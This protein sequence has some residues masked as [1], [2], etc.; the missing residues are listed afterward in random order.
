MTTAREYLAPL[1]AAYRTALAGL[2][3]AQQ[4]A[5][6]CSIGIEVTDSHERWQLTANGAD[7]TVTDEI[8]EP[9]DF[10]VYASKA[11]IDQ[12]VNDNGISFL[13][14][15]ITTGRIVPFK[16]LRGTLR[17]ALTEGDEYKIVFGGAAAPEAIM[18]MKQQDA[19]G[20]LTGTLNA[21]AAVFSGRIRIDGG[22][23]FLMSLERFV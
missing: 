2:P 4:A 3:V 7:V 8:S 9:V 5:V 1:I 22:M 18:R 17:L 6:Q 23:S 15:P 12:F 19:I 13:L 21:Q 10:R 14:R 11:R 20:L 16:A